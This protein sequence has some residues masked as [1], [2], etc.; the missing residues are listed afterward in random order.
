MGENF[1]P[2]RTFVGWK[3]NVTKNMGI[4]IDCGYKLRFCNTLD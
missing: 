1:F 2:N 3:V 4:I